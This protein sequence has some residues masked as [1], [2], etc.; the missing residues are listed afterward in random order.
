MPGTAG[1][2]LQKPTRF[3]QLLA[4]GTA[5]DKMQEVWWHSESGQWSGPLCLLITEVL[6]R[7][8]KP[9][10]AAHRHA[11]PERTLQA[12]LS[13]QQH[14]QTLM[15]VWRK[16]KEGGRSAGITAVPLAESSGMLCS[17][18]GWVLLLLL[19]LLLLSLGSCR[20]QSPSAVL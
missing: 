17:R 5:R 11:N 12:A 3:W 20:Q 9:S 16:E 10:C 14:V 2:V 15:L 4:S 1:S 8:M 13:P 6:I 7:Q 18:L 19:L